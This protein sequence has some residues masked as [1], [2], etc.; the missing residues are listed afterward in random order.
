MAAVTDA[1]FKQE[2][3]EFDGV[4]LVDFWADWCTPCHALEPIIEEITE[5]VKA[6]TKIKILKLNT[7]EN[8]EIQQRFGIMSIPTMIVFKNGQPADQ[9]VG[10]QPK[11][12]IVESINNA[13]AR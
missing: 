9:L 2:V 4:V 3:E 11:E 13:K 12:R 7:D 6:D 8:P 5:Q 10:V 1:T